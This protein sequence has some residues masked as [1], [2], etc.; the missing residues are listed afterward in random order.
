[1]EDSL[2]ARLPDPASLEAA[3]NTKLLYF[4]ATVALYLFGVA[5]EVRALRLS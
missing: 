5:H 3:P 2:H 1:M 4:S